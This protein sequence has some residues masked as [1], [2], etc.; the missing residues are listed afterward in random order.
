[1]DYI[2][3]QYYFFSNHQMVWDKGS[4][5]VYRD[6]GNGS[7]NTGLPV[8][9]VRLDATRDSSDTNPQIR[10]TFDILTQGV[11]YDVIFPYVVTTPGPQGIEIP[12][13]KFRYPL[14]V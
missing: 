13:I 4:L 6:D 11:D 2:K 9:I 12:V 3:R 7:N 14:N 1:M 10:G 5:K 8:G